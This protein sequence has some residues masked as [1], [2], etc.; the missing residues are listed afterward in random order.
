MIQEL[1]SRVA[2]WLEQEGAISGKD[3]G[4]FSYAVYSLLFGL[5]PIFI[6]VILG[7]A[8]GM[9]REGLLM[10]TPFMLIR[11]FSGGYH[12]DSPKLCVVLSI[13][14]L[15]L[16]MGFTKQIGQ[17]GDVT[18]LTVL[19][20]LSVICLCVF[21][22]VDNDFRK[23]TIKEKRIFRKVA[24]IVA[25]IFLIGYM[26]MCA[27]IPNQYTIAFGAGIILAATLQIIAVLA[28]ARGGNVV[29]PTED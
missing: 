7:L 1:S 23:L 21:S 11:K 20:S 2:K 19:V 17:E 13:A 8:F 26:I 18:L 9:L 12:L 22:P 27:T 4:L 3:S 10:I 6:V 16:A 14:L 29:L 24:C 5:L 15:T 25:I 28:K